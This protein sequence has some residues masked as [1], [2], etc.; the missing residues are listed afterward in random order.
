MIIKFKKIESYFEKILNCKM[1]FEKKIKKFKR[2]SKIFLIVG[3]FLLL[4]SIGIYIG[5]GFIIKY[6]IHKVRLRQNSLLINLS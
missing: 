1:D 6:Q 4:S 2:Y 5:C 3:L